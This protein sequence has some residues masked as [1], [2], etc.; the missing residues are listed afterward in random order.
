MI[1]TDLILNYCVC[2]IVLDQTV[3][4]VCTKEFLKFRPQIFS[5]LDSSNESEEI[6]PLENRGPRLTFQETGQENTFMFAQSNTFIQ[7]DGKMIETFQLR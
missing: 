2:D 6:I 1:K 7:I 5:V 4:C 3:S